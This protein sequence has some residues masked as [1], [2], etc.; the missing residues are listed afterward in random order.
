ME[1]KNGYKQTEIGPLPGDWNLL[2]LSS[3]AVISRLAGAEYTS[4][5][6]ETPDGEI[7]ALRGFN[8][9]KGNIIERDMVRIS[10]TLSMKLKRS[11]LTKGDVV[12][13][14]VGSIG[15]A[16]VIEEDNKYHIQQ[17]IARITPNQ[18]LLFPYYLVNF[19]MSSLGAKEVD[20]FNASSSQP[21]VLVGSLRQYNIPVPPTLAE[22]TAI[23]TA[24]S[25]TD[26]LIHSLE[27]LIAKKRA[28]KQGAMQELLTGKRR[29][30]GFEGKWDE[31]RLGEIGKC[32]RGVSYKP[33]T[34][35]YPHD[36]NNTIRLLRSNNVQDSTTVL[37]DI[38]FV[39][40]TRVKPLQILLDE[41]ILICMANGSKQLVG[42]AA[43]F[44]NVDSG[45]Y[46]FGAFMGCFRVDSSKADMSFVYYHF[47]TY[48]FRTYIDVL[49]SGSSINNLRPS[50]IEG[51]IIPFPDTI[52]QTAIAAVLSD[53]D[54]ELT[55][56]ESKLSKYRT[57]K[58]GMMQE[59]LT[60]KTRL[61]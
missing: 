60:G 29:L 23:A 3:I 43:R 26:A 17:N 44:C 57:I 22:Q 35:L 38:Q 41:D 50:N 12:Y 18:K 21:S 7:I 25:D 61:V 47:Q 13:P 59:L 10:N 51:V 53:M 42:K 28:I 37:S 54:S 45:R 2:Q 14:C 32:L 19:L 5:W 30:P 27:K 4:F 46:T 11:R 24:L 52:E 49:L 20:K 8:I 39:S 56:L 48:S 36:M 15:N 9:G 1:V 34:D 40:E 16:V 55:A 33:E 6:E 31:K 58:Q